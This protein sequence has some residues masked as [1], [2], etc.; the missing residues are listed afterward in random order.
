MM[1]W[2]VLDGLTLAAVTSTELGDADQKYG[3]PLFTMHRA[4]LHNELIRLA[5]TTTPGR[6]AVT[7]HVAS[8]VKTADSRIGAVELEDGTV[9]YADL[10]VGADGLHSATRAIVLQDETPAFK[11]SGMSAFRFQI[12]TAMLENNQ[13]FHKL[14]KSKGKGS[15]VLADTNELVMDRHL[16]WYGC[17]RYEPWPVKTAIEVD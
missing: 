13:H 15:T 1:R 5:T 7:M 3:A 17:R 10:I 6:R 8:T 14:L 4:D 11:S 12:P 16:V 2:E 9:L